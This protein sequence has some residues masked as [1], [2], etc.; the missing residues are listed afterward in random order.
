MA[1]APSLVAKAAFVCRTSAGA[2]AAA[3][4]DSSGNRI[5]LSRSWR[6][7]SSSSSSTDANNEAGEEPTLGSS[8]DGEGAGAAGK[9]KEKLRAIR[10]HVN[11]L[12]R[13]YQQQVELPE[14]WITQAYTNPSLPFHIDIGSA[15]GR[16][17]VEMAK[18]FPNLNLLGLEIR[19]PCVEEAFKKMEKYDVKGNI[20]FL[21]LNANVD[22]ERVVKQIQEHSEIARC[23]YT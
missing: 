7:W 18:T 9:K 3:R 1:S 13:N 20:H 11:P 15:R 16:F 5:D 4:L 10:Q 6:R 21:A 8:G 23:K 12:S 19:R 17:V 14:G 22:L 2:G